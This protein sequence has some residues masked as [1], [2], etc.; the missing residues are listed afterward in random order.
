VP[1]GPAVAHGLSHPGW[2]GLDGF[3]SKKSAGSRLYGATSTRAPSIIS[4]RE[5]RD[6]APYAGNE[7]TW[8]STWPSAS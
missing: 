2:P 8:N 3:H 1:A 7:G 4:S 6:S 5:R